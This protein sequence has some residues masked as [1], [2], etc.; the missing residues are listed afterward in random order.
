MPDARAVF[1]LHPKA[2]A[3]AVNDTIEDALGV[4]PERRGEEVFGNGLWCL[5]LLDDVRQRRRR[6]WLRFYGQNFSKFTHRLYAFVLKT[7]FTIP[8]SEK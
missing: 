8:G 3:F 4:L 2:L 5:G 6:L 1:G 7:S